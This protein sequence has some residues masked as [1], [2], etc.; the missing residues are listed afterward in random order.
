MM[1][2]REN[3]QTMGGLGIH[4]LKACSSA[5]EKAKNSH[6]TKAQTMGPSE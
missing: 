4:I 2:G 6:V 3:L 5:E 1:A